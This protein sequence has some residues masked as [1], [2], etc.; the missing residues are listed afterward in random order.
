[1]QDAMDMIN[2]K[3]MKSGGILQAVRT[4]EVADASNLL[5]MFGCM[6]ESRLAL[7]AAAHVVMSQRMA[8]YADLDAFLEHDVDPI[9]GGMQVK[10]GVSAWRSTRRSSGS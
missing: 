8:R 4:A 10:A 9:V 2:I 5:C 1:R 3:L 6:S 7:T